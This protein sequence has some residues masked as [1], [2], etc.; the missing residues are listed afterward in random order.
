MQ[1]LAASYRPEY[2]WMEPFECL[3]R[4]ALGSCLGMPFNDES[5]SA[6]VV[7]VVIC[8]GLV[9]FFLQARPYQHP[10][11]NKI[12]VVLVYAMTTL[13]FASLILTVDAMEP[14]EDELDDDGDAQANGGAGFGLIL[15]FVVGVG[16]AFAAVCAGRNISNGL[17]RM[18][19]QQIKF[20][21]DMKKLESIVERALK[22]ME[23]AL[24]NTDKTAYNGA[25]K[26]WGTVVQRHNESMDAR[27]YECGQAALMMVRVR[28][29]ARQ[30]QR[31]REVAPAA[32]AI[33][34]WKEV[35]DS[36]DRE[37]KL[38]HSKAALR[39]RARWAQ[40]ERFYKERQLEC[41]RRWRRG[42]EE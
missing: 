32:A 17:A 42:V 16:P 12:A 14:D 22:A 28:C 23:V 10:D 4:L 5:A 20:N 27:R 13:F 2:W 26:R 15:V 30:R 31:R 37:Q 36:E 7:A 35:R 34:G 3:R 41:L 39:V 33:R 1:F 38:K 8:L 29:A 6:P 21:R 40:N 11:D 19:R 9:Y 24:R 18:R 25:L